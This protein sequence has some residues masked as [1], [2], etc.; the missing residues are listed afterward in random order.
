MS[1]V[2]CFS[3]D[4]V[5]RALLDFRS[6]S[7]YPGCYGDRSCL[8]LIYLEMRHQV[9]SPSPMDFILLSLCHWQKVKSDF[10][11]NPGQFKRKKKSFLKPGLYTLFVPCG[12]SLKVLPL[13]SL[14]FPLKYNPPNSHQ[15]V[16][17][18]SREW[19]SKEGGG[20]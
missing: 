5:S 7:W 13:S 20:V 3:S 14:H 4:L 10:A 19:V 16:K 1:P 6:S 12:F 18:G 11:N 17:P 9:A 8:F 15:E 2:Q